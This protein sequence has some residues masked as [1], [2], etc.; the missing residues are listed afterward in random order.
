MQMLCWLCHGGLG[1]SRDGL[2]GNQDRLG[3]RQ[4][5]LG[6]RQDR[7]GGRQDGL[8][9]RQDRL[10]RAKVVIRRNCMFRQGA[11]QRGV[12]TPARERMAGP[13]RR[14]GGG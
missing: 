2:N 5:G 4:D 10:E 6:G 11:L 3:D 13:G 7:L 12:R 9:G 1:G 8:G 14:G